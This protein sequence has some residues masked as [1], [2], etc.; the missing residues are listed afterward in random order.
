MYGN[1]RTSSECWFPNGA[2]RTNYTNNVGEKALRRKGEDAKIKS[3]EAKHEDV[4]YI[5][6]GEGRVAQRGLETR[7]CW[8]EFRRSGKSA[9]KIHGSL[10]RAAVWQIV[11]VYKTHFAGTY[12]PRA[13]FS[14][15]FIVVERLA[16]NLSAKSKGGL[17]VHIT[18]SMARFDKEKRYFLDDVHLARARSCLIAGLRNFLPSLQVNSVV[19]KDSSE[20]SKN[21]LHPLYVVSK[22]DFKARNQ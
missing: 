15:D 7:Q 17:H 19:K 10:C 9:G 21:P 12:L 18:L 8:P 2:S 4:G 5:W 14:P 1:K 11:C 16:Q 3:K 13:F 22:S 6:R 20:F